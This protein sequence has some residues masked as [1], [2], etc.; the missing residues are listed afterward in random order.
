MPPPNDL[1]EY[2]FL[3][4]S[5]LLFRIA[6]GWLHNKESAE[7]AVQD[8]F[9]IA[10]QHMEVISIHSNPGGWLV[11][12]LKFILKDRI[13][14]ESRSP[15]FVSMYDYELSVQDDT[16]LLMFLGNFSEKEQELL[17]LKYEMGYSIKQI[18][19]FLNEKE[20]TVKSRL[21][22]LKNKIKKL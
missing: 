9:L 3:T 1:F 13:R 19:S 4:Y 21:F 8:T 20:G 15:E 17:F 16:S 10:S 22:R 18:S 5:K 14:S 7:D 6:L 12:T 11:Q 2:L